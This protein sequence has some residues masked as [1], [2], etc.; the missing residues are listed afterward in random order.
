MTHLIEGGA[1]IA[2]AELVEKLWRLGEIRPCES[3]GC[4]SEMIYKAYES[5]AACI[6]VEDGVIVHRCDRA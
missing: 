6:V 4:K 2:T 5:P 3:S 1:K